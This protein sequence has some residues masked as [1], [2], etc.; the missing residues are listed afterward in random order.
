M[1]S[2]V[3]PAVW[4]WVA[5]GLAIAWAPAWATLR[6]VE[7]D[8]SIQAAIDASAAGDTVRVEPGVYVEALR[9]DRP[10]RLEAAIADSV[11]ITVA[12]TDTAATLV[13]D[14]GAAVDSVEVYGLTLAE[15]S[16]HDVAGRRFGGALCIDGAS[17]AHLER[18]RFEESTAELG[19]GIAVLAGAGARLRDCSIAGNRASAAG[20][21][22]YAAGRV[23]A[24]SIIV[25]GNAVRDGADALAGSG[26][27]VEALGPLVLERSW[28]VANQAQAAGGLAVTGDGTRLLRVLV[29]RNQAA[30]TGG[31]LVVDG[32]SHLEFLSIDQ[33]AAATGGGIYVASGT[34]V[35]ANSIV[36]QNTGGG[37]D[38]GGALLRFNNRWNN[39][40][41]NTVMCPLG[42]GSIVANP[43]YV[44]DGPSP[45]ALA[46]N[47]P[48]IDS[49]DPSAPVPTDGGTRAD[50]GAF[51]RATG[52][53]LLTVAVEN[54]EDEPFA[55]NST[56]QI[57]VTGKTS[58]GVSAS[59]SA[60]FSD[61]DAT[62]TAGEEEVTTAPVEPPATFGYQVRYT[63]GNG[64]TGADKQVIVTATSSLGGTATDSVRIAVDATP[65]TPPQVDALP[66]AVPTA[67][68]RVEGTVDNPGEV[69]RVIVLVNG[70]EV[71]E[72]TPDEHGA[73]AV[74]V[75]LAARDNT[76]RVVAVDHAGNR[77][78]A[79]E[80]GTVVLT[81]VAFVDFPKRFTPGDA[82][83]VGSPGTD[84]TVRI[85]LYNLAGQEVRR[86][87]RRGDSL[88]QLTWDGRNGAG[89]SVNAGPYIAKI[90]TENHDAERTHVE[91]RAFVLAKG[92]SP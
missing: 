14:T 26:G 70:D 55:A 42:E 79:T 27:G 90:E 30:Q 72:G 31:G 76:I 46:L 2:K 16:G 34:P 24:D 22:L 18:C 7:A 82:F 51:E 59:V 37:I 73:F 58:P 64:N 85:S 65:P 25:E 29:A 33:N 10:L 69:A 57:L 88:V 47:S 71:A 54:R 62:Y 60:D 3:P 41:Q 6:T 8:G 20:G 87:S 81:Q 83:L 13:I 45:Y 38:C 92:G 39:S 66:D 23:V 5:I 19:G 48:C 40:P 89:Q 91:H 53:T 84:T 9:V 63:L 77:S 28:V 80:A 52:P 15:G 74:P 78:I 36:T 11:R 1:R 35:I 68:Y 61:A 17:R 44:G 21:G 4:S 50:I 32:S 86:L 49:A 12:A 67:I 75:R 56:V 43:R